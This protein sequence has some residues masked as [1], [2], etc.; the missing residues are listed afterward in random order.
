MLSQEQ[1]KRPELMSVVQDA[2]P[3][4]GD[5]TRLDD[6]RQPMLK[7]RSLLTQVEAA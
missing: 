5:D 6:R 1:S 4:S 3:L 2:L 7:G